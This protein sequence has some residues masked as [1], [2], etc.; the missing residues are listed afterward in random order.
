MSIKVPKECK[1]MEDLVRELKEKGFTI[2]EV[3]YDP[4]VKTCYVSFQHPI[5]LERHRIEDSIP[6]YSEILYG[7]LTNNNYELRLTKIT[8]HHPFPVIFYIPPVY[9]SRDSV[10][11][12]V[13]ISKRNEK[14]ST[15]LNAS[16]ISRNRKDIA[17]MI[18]YNFYLDELAG[19]I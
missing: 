7:F 6:L 5:V 2:K 9:V 18:I 17:L 8:D 1:D 12:Q 19:V 13:D 10:T 3:K 16:N 15:H 11:I 14:I 4:G